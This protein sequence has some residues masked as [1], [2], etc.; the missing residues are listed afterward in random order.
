MELKSILTENAPAPG[1]HYS[2]AIVHNGLVYVAGQLP[3]KPGSTEKTVGPI[4]E[5]AEQCLTNMR[6]ILRAAGSDMNRLLKVTIY[7]SDIALWGKVNEVYTR[8]LGA[9]RPARAI[10]PCK[11]LHYGF[12]VEIEAIAALN[13]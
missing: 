7:I 1:G 2:Q 8:M 6:E 5:Q 13:E 10:V 3:I 4:E 9:H 11:E 12:Q